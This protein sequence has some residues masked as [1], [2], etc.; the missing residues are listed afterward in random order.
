MVKYTQIKDV[1]SVDFEQVIDIYNDAFPENERLSLVKLR[2]KIKNNQFHLW[3]KK[4]ESKVIFM[5]ILCP[6][7]N[8]NFF[9]L[10]Y[11]ATDVNFRGKGIAKDFLLW[12]KNNRQNQHQYLLLEVENPAVGNDQ[13]VKEKR[14]QFYRK[15]GANIVNKVR[16]FLPEL[17]RVK[18]PEM[19]LM[20]YPSY[21]KDLMEG[22]LIKQLIESTYERFYDQ[23]QHPNMTLL[24]DNIPD[25]LELI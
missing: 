16:Y 3:V 6:L 19:I 4:D 18:A 23:S 14:V 17:S 11:I 24:F 12:W 9:L 25:Q 1:D 2:E 22:K 7:V 15:L 10:G 5:A 21:E 13:D 20:I 8:S